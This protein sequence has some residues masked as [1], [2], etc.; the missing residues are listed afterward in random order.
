MVLMVLMV[1]AINKKV[2]WCGGGNMR[3]KSATGT[4]SQPAAK[5]YYQP[6]QGSTSYQ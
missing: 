4:I 5:P 2:S 6:L 3:T 1:P